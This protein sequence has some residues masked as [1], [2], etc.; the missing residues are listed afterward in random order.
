MQ[1]NFRKGNLFLNKSF[2]ELEILELGKNGKIKNAKIL[3]KTRTN[4]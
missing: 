4:K 2:H 3:I 1:D